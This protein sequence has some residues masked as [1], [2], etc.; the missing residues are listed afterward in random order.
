MR[1]LSI[2]PAWTD[3]GIAAHTNAHIL[4]TGVDAA[5]CTHDIYHQHWPEVR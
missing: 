5:E 2:H 1:S 3:T 4:V